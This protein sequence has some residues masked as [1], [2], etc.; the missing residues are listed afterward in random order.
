MEELNTIQDVKIAWI[1]LADN[2][3]SIGK[4]EVAY[5]LLKELVFQSERGL[6]APFLR[7][8]YFKHL[9]RWEKVNDLLKYPA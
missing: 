4:K 3:K 6:Q 2:Y 8:L 9:N 7:E 5:E 1:N